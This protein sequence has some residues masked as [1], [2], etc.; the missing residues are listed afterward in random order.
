MDD[1]DNLQSESALQDTRTVGIKE[2]VIESRHDLPAGDHSSKRVAIGHSLSSDD[3]VRLHPV[4]LEPP[5]FLAD[6]AE[7]SL[8]LVR[9]DQSSVLSSQ[10]RQSLKKPL[11]Q[12][13]HTS[14]A[15]GRLGPHTRYLVVAGGC[16]GVL[17]VPDQGIYGVMWAAPQVRIRQGVDIG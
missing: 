11:W 17:G 10:V 16:D 2:Q 14:H 3:D 12:G 13:N 7:A 5:H 8:D 6:P 15:H 9:N 1:L 4:V